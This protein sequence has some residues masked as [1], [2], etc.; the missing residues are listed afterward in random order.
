[1][2]ISMPPYHDKITFQRE[3]ALCRNTGYLAHVLSAP[4]PG[5]CFPLHS[6]DKTQLVVNDN[7]TYRRVSNICR[8]R[9][10]RIL[11]KPA[12]LKRL[13]CPVHRWSYALDGTL[14]N[15]PRF[16]E[17][18]TR[19]L[20]SQTLHNW[21]GLLFDL[22]PPD[23]DLGA[24][25][26]GERLGFEGFRFHAS[27]HTD[28]NFHWRHFLEIYL[29]NYHIN[30]MHPGLTQFIDPMAL[31]WEFYPCASIQ[32]VGFS[33]KL[34]PSPDSPEVYDRLANE[35]LDMTGGEFP[36]Y[37]T[38]WSLF[39]PN[40]MIE[41]YPFVRV[42]S[43]IW[44]LTPDRCRNSVEIFFDSAMEESHP[45]YFRLFEDAYFATAAEDE[46]ACQMLHDGRRALEM[47]GAQDDTV[48]A[49]L[50]EDGVRAFYEYLAEA[51]SVST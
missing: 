14:L 29:E 24:V 28:Y 38:I 13:I 37:A 20:Q 3:Q 1:M 40:L 30:S 18:P 36:R 23:L 5:D 12:Q 50:L 42:I 11:D 21:H 17:C 6:R 10:A 25:D 43:T 26:C 8:H 47:S 31:E 34:K 19:P 22:A 41:S 35:L 49:P 46:A 51:S 16:A 48:F 33:R 7:G 44:P 27:S 9:Q 39:Y 32:K 15:A 45:Q 2:P 4:Q